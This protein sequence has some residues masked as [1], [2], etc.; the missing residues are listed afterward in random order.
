[1][2]KLNEYFKVPICN[3]KDFFLKLG[4]NDQLQ[5]LDI[6]HN[7]VLRDEEMLQNLLGTNIYQL[8]SSFK[9]F[10]ENNRILQNL[11]LNG[12]LLGDEIVDHL[13]QGI[14]ESHKGSALKSLHL[15]NN[16]IGD[17]AILDQLIPILGSKCP[18]LK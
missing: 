8:N 3:A 1:M 15:S 4:E 18:E 9:K 6:S 12:C 17:K 10:T 16:N 7:V 2:A 13:F 14:R 11:N 5:N